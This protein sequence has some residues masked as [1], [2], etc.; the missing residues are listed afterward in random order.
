M[1]KLV[2]VLLSLSMLTAFAGCSKKTEETSKKT[3]KTKGTE[4]TETEDPDE[5]T[6]KPTTSEETE[7]EASS[8]ETSE[9]SESSES[10]GSGS[11]RDLTPPKRPK[12]YP[13][14]SD[15]KIHEDVENL[16]FNIISTPRAYAMGNPD[17]EGE[18]AYR[19]F[20][21]VEKFDFFP[22]TVEGYE[23][24]WNTVQ[25]NGENLDNSYNEAYNKELPVFIKA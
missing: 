20:K 13:V 18:P 22:N 5:S 17:V 21:N 23:Q 11:V 24:L 6:V 3:K 8:S 4:I 2:A 14:S 16:Q 12:D 19:I 9:T 25:A 7:T 15:F 10:S 1:K